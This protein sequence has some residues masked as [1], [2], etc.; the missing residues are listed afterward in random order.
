MVCRN[1]QE[2]QHGK[3]ISE[4]LITCDKYFLSFLPKGS[5]RFHFI[6]SPGTFLAA[7]S[8]SYTLFRVFAQVFQFLFFPLF[9]LFLF[10]FYVVGRVCMSVYAMNVALGEP[11]GGKS[12][13]YCP[14]YNALFPILFTFRQSLQERRRIPQSCFVTEGLFGLHRNQLTPPFPLVCTKFLRHIYILYTYFTP[15]DI[16]FGVVCCFPFPSFS[17]KAIMLSHKDKRKG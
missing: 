13:F 9:S 1:E 5:N 16:L 10:Y 6:L 4:I 8:F 2:E 11:L 14:L 7:Y 3:V 15:C 17:L 12:E